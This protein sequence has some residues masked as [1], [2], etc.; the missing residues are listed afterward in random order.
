[1]TA[2]AFD[3][4]SLFRG[5]K[6]VLADVS[7][8]VEEGEFVGLLGPNGAGKTTLL[9]AI[10]GLIPAQSGRITVHGKS[11]R[12]GNPAAGYMPQV[13]RAVGEHGLSGEAFVLSVAGGHRW[14]IPVPTSAER[15]EAAWAL[16]AVGASALAKRPLS[17][18]SGGE[19][20]RLLLAQALIGKPSLLLLD[21]PLLSLDPSRQT[22]IVELVRGLQKE[23]GIAVLFS[24]HELNPLLGA[25][26]KVLYLGNGQAA[27]GT[28]EDVITGPVLSRLYGAAID[29]LRIEGRIFVMA[30]QHDVER[31]EH[32]HD[33]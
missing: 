22:G 30:S 29:V 25:L 19:R 1:M 15:R 18:I 12:R 10:L 26:D 28:V 20:Q 32:R 33:V 24:A 23:M 17:E 13:R 8:A 11:P 9:K 7:F 2:V 16:D 4:V 21:E 6:R 3:R 27:I 14:G 5:D 31:V